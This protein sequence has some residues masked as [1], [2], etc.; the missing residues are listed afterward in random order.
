M[1]VLIIGYGNMGREIEKVL[2]TRNH[3]TVARIDPVD[4]EADG[5]TLEEDLAR[6]SDVAIEF[7]LPEAVLPNIRR[8]VQYGISAVVG[9]T[10]W[11]DQIGA[12]Q[13]LLA[14]NTTGLVYGSNFSIGAHLFLSLVARA[15]SLVEAIP[16][17]DILAYELHHKRKKDSPSGTALSVANV[18]LEN[19]SRKT[20]IVTDK[21]DRKRE[22][23]ELHLASARGG[24]LP[25]I[26][27]VLVDSVADTIELT[28][29]AR[30][31]SGFALGA[32]MA[33]EWIQGKTGLHTVSDFI[34]KIL[35]ERR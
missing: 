3:V 20:E 12:V 29:R 7:S 17:Y 25:G 35:S 2:S 26:H 14:P 19:S 6:R 10:G 33:A 4:S 21:L 1:D 27:S 32:V 34:Q 18:I 22:D 31:R 8:Y 16:D 23:H 24:E 30:N 15:T 9:T 11:Y 28:H 5:R 13:E